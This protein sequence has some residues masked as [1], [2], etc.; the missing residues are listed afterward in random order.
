MYLT[1]LCDNYVDVE[2]APMDTIWL[3]FSVN[4]AFANHFVALNHPHPPPL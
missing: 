2:M 1:A 4:A 3:F